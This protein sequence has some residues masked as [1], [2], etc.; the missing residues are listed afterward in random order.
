MRLHRLVLA[1]L[2]YRNGTG[3][4]FLKKDALYRVTMRYDYVKHGGLLA[5]QTAL[6][7][8]EQNRRAKSGKSVIRGV[9][10][11]PAMLSIHLQNMFIATAIIAEG[12]KKFCFP[13]TKNAIFCI[14]LRRV[15]NH[16]WTAER[17]PRNEHG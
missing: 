3:P 5:L 12:R 8:D 15:F 2:C 1:C 6:Q 14:F 7:L 9:S 11:R 13:E 10:R 4:V 17:R 16:E